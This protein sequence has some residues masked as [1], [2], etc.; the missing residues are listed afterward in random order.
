M[1]KEHRELSNEKETIANE[2][3]NL[4]SMHQDAR[5]I[6][7]S[8]SSSSSSLSVE[9]KHGRSSSSLLTYTTRLNINLFEEGM[10][11]LL[12]SDFKYKD[13][14]RGRSMV[15]ASANSGFPMAVAYCH[16][17]D[18]D[19]RDSGYGTDLDMFVKIEQEHNGYHWAQYVLGN[20]CR[21][22]YGTDQDYTKAV[23]WWTK[24]SE[25][26]N[27]LA[28]CNLGV[29]CEKGEGC[30]QNQTKAVEWYERSAQLGNSAAMCNLGICYEEGDGVTKDLNKA[31]EWYTK[32]AGQGDACAQRNLDSLNSFNFN[33]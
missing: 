9:S 8:N 4:I 16:Y 14:E 25:L 31:R 24:S 18:Y 19:Y 15:E 21:Y 5:A 33:N 1:N 28:M 23:E 27:S 30:D 32:A 29:R 2:L 13:K 6:S 22:G 26:G 12:G 3:G 7:N 17:R 10:A 20:C 11:Y